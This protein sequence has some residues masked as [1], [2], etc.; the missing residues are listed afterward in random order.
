MLIEVNLTTSKQGLGHPLTLGGL[1][2]VELGMGKPQ[3]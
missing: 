3:T 2:S 1:C